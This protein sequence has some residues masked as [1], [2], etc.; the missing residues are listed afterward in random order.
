VYCHEF[1]PPIGESFYRKI[2]NKAFYKIALA[3][4]IEVEKEQEQPKS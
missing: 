1:N 4:D 2:R 3:L